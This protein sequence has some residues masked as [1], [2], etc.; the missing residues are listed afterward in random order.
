MVHVRRSA[1]RD[2][3]SPDDLAEAPAVGRRPARGRPAGRGL[4]AA[5]RLVGRAD[6][7]RHHGLAG[8]V[9]GRPAARDEV[10]RS[11]R[12]AAVADPACDVPGRVALLRT[13]SCR[14]GGTVSSRRIRT[15]T[16][17]PRADRAGCA[18]GVRDRGVALAGDARGATAGRSRTC[19]W[20]EPSGWR[21]ADSHEVDCEA[22]GAGAALAETPGTPPLRGGSLRRREEDVPEQLAP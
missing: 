6:A 5:L 2:R 1:E 18:G 4:A 22:T 9:H 19:S 8:G 16:S 17:G 21:R 10:R 3:S 20:R 12:G 11:I 13:F 14:D 15:A 7:G